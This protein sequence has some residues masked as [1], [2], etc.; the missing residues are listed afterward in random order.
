MAAVTI[1]PFDGDDVLQQLNTWAATVVTKL[2]TLTAGLAEANGRAFLLQQ[3][4][5]VKTV[6]VAENL[7]LVTTAGSGALNT[8]I[9]GFRVELGKH[10]YAHSLARSQIE[11]VVSGAERKFQETQDIAKTDANALYDGFKAECD[12]RGAA[13]VHLRTELQVKFAVLEGMLAR[14][15][16]SGAAPVGAAPVEEMTDDWARA[17]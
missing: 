3:E 5:D 14:T 4:V 7:R 11:A 6:E 10:E 13:D 1:P 2:E 12:R 17:W 8:V 9:E 16:S 15:S